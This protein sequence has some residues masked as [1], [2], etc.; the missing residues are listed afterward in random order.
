MIIKTLVFLCFLVG[1]FAFAEDKAKVELPTV[2]I[3]GNEH[4]DH[5]HVFKV[6]KVRTSDLKRSSNTNLTEIVKHQNGVE[7]QTY[8]ANCG[9]K[10]LTINGLKGEHTSILID[11]IPLH[12]AVSSFYGVDSIPANGIAEI[13]VMRGSGASLINPESIGGTLNVITTDPFRAE[14]SY[15]ISTSFGEEKFNKSSNISA[16][17][18]HIHKEKKWAISIGAQASFKDTW[19]VDNNSVA[20][21]PQSKNYSAFAKSRHFIPSSK[22]EAVVR[23]GHSKLEI[24]GGAVKPSKPNSVRAVAAQES[25]FIDG[26]VHKKFVGDNGKITDWIQVE[27]TE[28]TLNYKKHLLKERLINFKFGYAR[29]SQSAIYQH[30]FD[31]SNIDNLIVGDLS[32]RKAFIDGNILTFGVFAKDERLRSASEVLFEKYPPGD[33]RDIEKDNFN[34]QSYALYGQYNL[35]LGGSVE[36]DIALRV[37]SMSIDWL[38]LSHSINEVI[39]APRAQVLHNFNDHLS[40]RFSYGLGYRSP[41][42]FFE[43]QHGNNE[44]GY[45]VGITD[46]EK[47][48]SGVYSLSYST[49]TY[50][51]TMSSH[52]TYL[53]NMAYGFSQFNQPIVYKN[54]DENFHITVSDLLLGYKPSDQYLLEFVFEHF[55]YQ[56]G[57]KKKLPTAAIENRI[58]LRSNYESKKW[59]HSFALNIVYSR[60]LSKYGSYENHY[61]NRD[62]SSEP[63]LSASMVKKRQESPTYATL[64]ASLTYK[65]SKKLK[66][67]LAVNNIFDYTQI[68][69]GDSPATWHW[70]FNH[71]HFDGLHTWGPSRGRE[72]YLNLSGNF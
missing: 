53:Q 72:V 21:I 8:C 35:L 13:E 70:H 7:A 20:E 2:F 36:A 44:S 6:E 37:D 17:Y 46:L 9:A 31:Y 22:S 45:K 18:N 1:S 54:T 55:N 26:S 52:Y 43:S 11:G 15:L 67:S 29:Q 59:D 14:N 64:D 47:A 32:Y 3:K 51:V 10:R 58:Q 28:A 41:L 38:E 24:L 40:Q 5:S 71:A 42:T 57:Y 68:S 16:L 33:S 27:R 56:D 61:I 25:D 62:Q 48:H 50:Y 34:L 30:G 39:V 63:T 69:A 66:W 65:Q 23:V 49:P 19:D 60:D 4:I 12:S